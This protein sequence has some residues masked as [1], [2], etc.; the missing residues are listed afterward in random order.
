MIPK[1]WPLCIGFGLWAVAFVGLYALQYLGCHLG[2][3]PVVHRSA[4]LLAY[5]VSLVIMAATLAFQI[6]RLRK[7]GE[8]AN[9][10]ERI[11]TGATI[12]ALAATAI[13][14]APTLIASACL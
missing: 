2:W 12:A 3:D 13:T 7:M 5:A 8:G 6:V 10:L 9:S 1:L 4:L 11:G 14:F